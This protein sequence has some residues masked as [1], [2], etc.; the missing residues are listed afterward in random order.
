[1]G[2]GRQIPTWAYGSG[3]GSRGAEVGGREL[4][5]AGGGGG[6]DFQEV[7]ITIIVIISRP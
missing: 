2:C 1:V 7:P 6:I 4:G 3:G 5:G